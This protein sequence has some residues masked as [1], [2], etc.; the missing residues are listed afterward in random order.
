MRDQTVRRPARYGKGPRSRAGSNGRGQNGARGRSDGGRRNANGNRLS[1]NGGNRGETALCIKC[2]HPATDGKLC[3]F[4][5]MLL[6]T[7]RKEV[8]EQDPRRLHF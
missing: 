3:A 7:F 6:N 2:G 1:K 8:P 4:H 5:R